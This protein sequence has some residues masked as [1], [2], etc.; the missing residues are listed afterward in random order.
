MMN[1]GRDFLDREETLQNLIMLLDT[2]SKKKRGF[3][4]AIDGKWGCGK[5]FLLDMLDERVSVVQDEESMDDRY[6]I[7]RYD[8]WKYD[9]YAEPLMAIL[10]ALREQIKAEVSL[11]P[12]WKKS[13]LVNGAVDKMKEC[14]EE[15]GGKFLESK[16]GFNPVELYRQCM[17]AGNAREEK[18]RAFDTYHSLK[19]VLDTS[20][21]QLEEIAKTKTIVFIVDELDRCLPEYAIKVLECL[22]HVLSGIPNFITVLSVDKSVL[23]QVVRKAYGPQIDTTAYLRK[24]VDFSFRLNIGTP[25]KNYLKKYSDYVGKF[26]GDQQEFEWTEKLLILLMNGLDIRTQ[27]KIL[28]KAEVI[29]DIVTDEKIDVS[30]MAFEILCV[31]QSYKNKKSGAAAGGELFWSVFDSRAANRTLENLDTNARPQMRH[32]VQ[33]GR[34]YTILENG[35]LDK[36][37]WYLEN[38]HST[39]RKEY[40]G[41]YYYPDYKN[42]EGNVEKMKLFV[43]MLEILE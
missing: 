18:E 28:S 20:R 38:V 39:A 36:V 17:D 10:A 14:L 27:E 33:S 42:A 32:M 6:F 40:C 15:G 7:V 37:K 8:C 9:Y 43:R 21:K 1:T 11:I 24:I 29:H 19:E 3:T 22:H 2:L 26:E 34:D 13:K 25:A 16:L 35:I 31:G 41:E 23:E 30:C 12:G 4:F 5:T